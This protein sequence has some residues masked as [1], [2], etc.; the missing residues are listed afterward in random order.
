MSNIKINLDLTDERQ[1]R[2][3]AAFANEIAYGDGH[4]EIVV[5]NPLQ[6]LAKEAELR[7]APEDVPEKSKT[8]RKKA[9]P[10]TEAPAATEATEAEAP[11]PEVVEAEKA[12]E[13]RNVFAEKIAESATKTTDPNSDGEITRDDLR[14][15]LALKRDKHRDAITEKLH[16]LDGK[17]ISLLEPSKFAAMKTFM[18][19]LA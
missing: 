6:V 10:V 19:G 5:K 8:T 1:V 7:P 3:L 16:Q 2:A 4:R 13:T 15:L 14:A 12:P 17:S 11:T 9:A 18:E